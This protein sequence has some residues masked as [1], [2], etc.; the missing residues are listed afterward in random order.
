MTAKEDNQHEL[1]RLLRLRELDQDI[2]ERSISAN[3]AECAALAK[4]FDLVELR[5]L[6]ASLAVDRVPDSLLVRVTGSLHA[7]VVQR[8][9][10]TLE[11]FAADVDAPIDELFGPDAGTVE[12]VDTQFE[13]AVPPEPFDGDAIDLG[14]L[15]AQQLALALDPYPK[16][17]DGIVEG[18][19]TSEQQP[20][21][22]EVTNKPFAELADWHKIR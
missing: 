17:S 10:V 16:K 18:V 1:S 21:L 19:Y 6:S 11:P 7:E 9:I 15:A 13:E 8:C 20:G 4:R 3:S 14:E 5:C 12:I 2:V 22:D